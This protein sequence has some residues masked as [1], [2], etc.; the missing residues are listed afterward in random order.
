[1]QE[2]VQEH[3]GGTKEV[4]AQTGIPEDGYKVDRWMRGIQRKEK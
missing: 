1:M 4:E 3:H 2:L